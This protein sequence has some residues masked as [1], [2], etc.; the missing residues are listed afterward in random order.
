[1]EERYLHLDG[2]RVDPEQGHNV[3]LISWNSANHS[4]LFA[5]VLPVLL[6][7]H[8]PFADVQKLTRGGGG[9]AGGVSFS[10]KSRITMVVALSSLR[11]SIV[12]AERERKRKKIPFYYCC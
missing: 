8:V 3:R 6:L 4:C 12:R 5:R 1:M 9:G 11:C 10:N 2:S 7:E